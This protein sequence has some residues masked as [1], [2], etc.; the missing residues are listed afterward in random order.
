MFHLPHGK[1]W[2]PETVCDVLRSH[3]VNASI[4]G[5]NIR[6]TLRGGKR[7]TILSRVLEV[8]NLRDPKCVSLNYYPAKFIYNVDLKDFW[9]QSRLD[10]SCL[11]DIESAM[12]KLGCV[13]DCERNIA[14]QYCP[15]N[16]ILAG[17]FNEIDRLRVA[18]DKLIAVQ[19]FANAALRL[20]EEDLIRIQ[21]DAILFA[22]VSTK[23]QT[24]CDE[25]NGPPKPPTVVYSNG[26]VT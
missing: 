13:I 15:D 26:Q 14:A 12:L 25:Q 7:Q 11:D 4:T 19:D 17:L 8:L 18:I 23:I 9:P 3:C 22:S 20:N 10:L 5:P 6:I 16:A 2:N 21:M 24:K 1:Y